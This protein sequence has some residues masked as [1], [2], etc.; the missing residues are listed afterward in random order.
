MATAVISKELYENKN[1]I[2]VPRDAYE[3]FLV[4]QKE[5]KSVKTFTPTEKDKKLLKKAREN[6]KKGNYLT[7]DELK[8]KLG[9]KN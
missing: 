8:L 6:Y 3:E 4:W 7:L 1:L 2:A 5:I 9:I